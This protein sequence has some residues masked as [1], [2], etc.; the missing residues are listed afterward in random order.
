MPKQKITGLTPALMQTSTDS[1]AM[2]EAP[3]KPITQTVKVPPDVWE[4]MKVIGTKQRRTNQDIILT[5]V[6]E[7]LDKL[8]S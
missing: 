7:Y 1:S 4:Q 5:A 8:A 2:E 3:K 6:K